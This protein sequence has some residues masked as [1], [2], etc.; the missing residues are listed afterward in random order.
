MLTVTDKREPV[1]VSG[2]PSVIASYKADVMTAADYS[3]FGM[4]LPGRAYNNHWQKYRYGFNGQE[5]DHEVNG[6]YNSYNAEFWQYEPRVGRRW[7]VDPKPTVGIS[8]YAAFNNSPIY[9]SD[10]YGDT[11][12]PAAGNDL[13]RL[14]LPTNATFETYKAEATYQVGGKNVSVKPGQLRSFSANGKTFQARWDTNSLDFLGY[15]DD[16]GNSGSQY[17]TTIAEEPEITGVEWI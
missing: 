12:L 5:A 15:K 3:P 4:T 16:A 17:L 14:V 9:N 8:P 13:I 2:N 11:I 10:P 6:P 1:P 7:N